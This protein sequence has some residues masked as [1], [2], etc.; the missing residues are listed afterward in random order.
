[1]NATIELDVAGEGDWRGA[2]ARAARPRYV[3]GVPADKVAWRVVAEHGPGGGN[4]L[5]SATG[6]VRGLRR[7]VLRLYGRE[8]A[9][10]FWQAR[11]ARLSDQEGRRPGR[12][13]PAASSV[14]EEGR[15][16]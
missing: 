8:G 1:M 11:A 14:L 10:D 6:S 9:R 13:G 12:G 15:E 5:V 4:P 16:E 3:G 7:F 2:V